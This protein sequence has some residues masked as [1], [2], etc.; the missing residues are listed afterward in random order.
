MADELKSSL[1]CFAVALGVVA[2]SIL[3]G[4]VF[5]WPVLILAIPIGLVALAAYLNFG[6]RAKTRDDRIDK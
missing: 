6:P 1:G 2:T 4:L 3:V 5:N